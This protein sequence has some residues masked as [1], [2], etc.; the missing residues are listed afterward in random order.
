MISNKDGCATISDQFK[1]EVYDNPTISL[2]QPSTYF[3]CD[4]VPITLN[5]V[6][7]SLV[8]WYFNGQPIVGVTSSQLKAHRGGVY[9]VK[10]VSSNGCMTLSDTKINLNNVNI[11]K[12]DFSFL[13]SC[14]QFPVAFLNET[15][16]GDN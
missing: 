12:P 6:T 14:I 16:G 11:P 15:K 8:Y 4:S 9:E 10:A 5:A 7:N 3:I 1:F 2:L 13:N